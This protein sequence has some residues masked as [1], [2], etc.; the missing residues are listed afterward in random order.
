MNACSECEA[1][2]FKDTH[3]P[4]ML[5]L[6]CSCVDATIRHQTILPK[7]AGSA[8]CRVER[9]ALD[10]KLSAIAT[11]PTTEVGSRADNK[12]GHRDV[13]SSKACGNRNRLRICSRRSLRSFR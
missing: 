9:A 2:L 5:R 7:K 8:S 1:L 12:A 13:G 11:L 3:V 10:P 6:G 4:E